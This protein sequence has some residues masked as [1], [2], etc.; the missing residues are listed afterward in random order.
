MIPSA[1]PGIT[2]HAEDL[3][4]ILASIAAGLDV[5]RS[6]VKEPINRPGGPYRVTQKVEMVLD[7]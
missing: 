1:N 7:R 3:F 4:W 5:H 2:C 6:S